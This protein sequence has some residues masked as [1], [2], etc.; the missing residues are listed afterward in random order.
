MSNQLVYVSNIYRCVNFRKIF[1]DVAVLHLCIA[2][3][4]IRKASQE[5]QKVIRVIGIFD[6]PCSGYQPKIAYIRDRRQMQIGALSLCVGLVFTDV[7]PLFQAG[8]E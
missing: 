5:L 1:M 4:L 3:D 6:L 7:V 8:Q 2:R